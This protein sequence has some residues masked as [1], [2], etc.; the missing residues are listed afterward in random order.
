M[1]APQSQTQVHQS[2]V[3]VTKV[4]SQANVTQ[5]SSNEIS[6]DRKECMPKAFKSYL[7]NRYARKR[8]Q[9]N[10]TTSI[11][12]PT[13]LTE[14]EQP[15][16]SCQVSVVAMAGVPQSDREAS[17]RTDFDDL[18]SWA[19]LQS[20]NVLVAGS[21]SNCVKRP[22]AEVSPPAGEEASQSVLPPLTRPASEQELPLP[23]PAEA[24]SPPESV[25]DWEEDLDTLLFD[26]DGSVCSCS[27]ETDVPLSP[28][29]VTFS[30][31]LEMDTDME[32]DPQPLQLMT[33][34]RDN[35][36]EGPL[37]TTPAADLNLQICGSVAPPD[38][39]TPDRAVPRAVNAILD[40]FDCLDG[41]AFFDEEE[42]EALLNRQYTK[43]KGCTAPNCSSVQNTQWSEF[44][45][46]QENDFQW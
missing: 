1:H 15:R 22:H 35:A 31:E 26:E 21:D 37:Q 13:K 10:E 41:Y 23:A 11:G 43:V 3:F 42:S 25:T 8:T 12:S 7:C 19:H 17:M 20:P 18:E 9:E 24:V 16:Q 44:D 38:T 28:G 36:A 6:A 30:S 32:E 46:V 4:Q 39:G 27:D 14:A 34:E 40:D 45:N 2:K 33:E 29:D 5:S